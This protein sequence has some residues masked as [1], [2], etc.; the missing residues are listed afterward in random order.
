MRVARCGHTDRRMFKDCQGLRWKGGKGGASETLRPSVDDGGG[1]G[2]R[3]A[4]REWCARVRMQV[5]V[6]CAVLVR[7]GV[8]ASRVLPWNG[9][10]RPIV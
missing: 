5:W 10:G 3:E 6:G 7:V 4:G 9:E 2:A 8:S 1:C